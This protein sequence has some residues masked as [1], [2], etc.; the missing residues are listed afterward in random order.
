M[1]DEPKTAEA[2]KADKEAMTWTI[3]SKVVM[4][5]TMIARRIVTMLQFQKLWAKKRAGTGSDSGSTTTGKDD[6]S[7]E[8]EVDSS[9]PV[10]TLYLPPR[11]EMPQTFT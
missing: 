1:E 4:M 6:L 8:G 7:G 10:E 5:T 2:P 9:R 11:F 3:S